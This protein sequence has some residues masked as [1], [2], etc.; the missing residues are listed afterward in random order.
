MIV[1]LLSLLYKLLNWALNLYMIAIAVY[2]LMSWFPGAPQSALGRF[3]GRIVDPYLD[4]FRRFIP[5]I[6]GMDFSPI[7]AF[8]LLSFVNTWLSYLFAAILNAV[9]G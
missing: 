3:L 4:W 1:T 6:L 9:V 5:P 8:L 7:L 2:V